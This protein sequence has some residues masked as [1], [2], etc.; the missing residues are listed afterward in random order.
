MYKSHEKEPPENKRGKQ[1]NS[2]F[3]QHSYSNLIHWE[4]QNKNFEQI[5]FNESKEI[6]KKRR[7]RRNELQLLTLILRI[8]QNQHV[9]YYLLQNFG[10]SHRNEF[11]DRCLEMTTPNDFSWL[12]FVYSWRVRYCSSLCAVY[13]FACLW[14]TFIWFFYFSKKVLQSTSLSIITVHFDVKKN[15]RLTRDFEMFLHSISV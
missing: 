15:K 11:K 10:W 9:L 4:I 1:T 13:Y 3:Y 5:R 8:V 14:Y 7:R 6:S 12:G 2:S